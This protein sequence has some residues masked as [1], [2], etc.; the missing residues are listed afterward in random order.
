MGKVGI[1]LFKSDEKSTSAKYMDASRAN[2]S[3][4]DTGQHQEVVSNMVQV[5]AIE[6]GKQGTI[7]LEKVDVKKS[8]LE[9][10]V[11][12]QHTGVDPDIDKETA[13]AKLLFEGSYSNKEGFVKNTTE[14]V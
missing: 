4:L 9:S 2:Y 14:K 12:N 7:V 5:I 8:T 13:V 10:N 11:T 3:E 1:D 6:G